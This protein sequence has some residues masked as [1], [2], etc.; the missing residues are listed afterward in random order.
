MAA[1][2]QIRVL[3]AGASGALGL[4]LTRRLV[5]AGHQV[6]GLARSASKRTMIE[7]IGASVVVADALDRDAV[8]AVVH[9][10][11]PTHLVNL[12]TALP[13]GGAMRS[14]DLRPTNRLRIEGSRNLLAAALD[15]GVRRIVKPKQESSSGKAS[16]LH[17]RPIRRRLGKKPGSLGGLPIRRPSEKV[18]APE[19]KHP[20][21]R[22][23]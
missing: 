18:P 5:G 2:E 14:G 1:N 12:L 20:A 17:Y 3:I 23:P 7:E 16:G 11:K 6:T 19:P 10:A 13:P 9:E 4:P 21:D 15:A 22:P 8:A